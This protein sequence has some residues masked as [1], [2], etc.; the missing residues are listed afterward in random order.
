MG[1]RR[2]LVEL[3]LEV[4]L[5]AVDILCDAVIL[6]GEVIHSDVGILWDLG[7]LINVGILCYLGILGKADIL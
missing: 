5:N 3:V 4:G 1:H 2:R 7:I 6:G